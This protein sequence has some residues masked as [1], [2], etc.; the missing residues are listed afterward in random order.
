MDRYKQVV[1]DGAVKEACRCFEKLFEPGTTEAERVSRYYISDIEMELSNPERVREAKDSYSMDNYFDQYDPFSKW[2]FLETE[3]KVMAKLSKSD[4]FTW[5]LICNITKYL[6]DTEVPVTLW[7]FALRKWASNRLGD[8]LETPP[9]KSGRPSQYYRDLVFVIIIRHLVDMCEMA[10]TSSEG[11]EGFSAADAVVKAY[12]ITVACVAEEKEYEEIYEEQHKREFSTVAKAWTNR[13]KLI[14]PYSQI[15]DNCI[16]E[17]LISRSIPL[18]E[19]SR[20]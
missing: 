9:K 14:S 4:K 2:K 8:K 7:P 11:T 15:R 12:L 17:A 18:P 1:F 19:L 13:H 3:F 20:R 6:H 16:I 5:N 10:A